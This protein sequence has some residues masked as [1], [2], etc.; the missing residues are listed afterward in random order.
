[1]GVAVET[2]GNV[3]ST[4]TWSGESPWTIRGNSTTVTLT[5]ANLRGGVTEDDRQHRT[6][7]ESNWSTILAGFQKGV[8]K[9]NYPLSIS[10]IRFRRGPEHN[11]LAAI[12]LKGDHHHGS[13][14]RTRVHESRRGH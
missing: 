2:D 5:Q 7:Y 6:D 13:C 3:G 11:Q 9:V 4:I 1:M 12:T 10:A 14:S 8:R